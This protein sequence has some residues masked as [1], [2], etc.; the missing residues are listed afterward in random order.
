MRMI[1]M[2][3][4]KTPTLSKGVM[5]KMGM[6]LDL[7]QKVPLMMYN[8]TQSGW[9]TIYNWKLVWEFMHTTT[10]W[11]LLWRRGILVKVETLMNL[12]SWKTFFLWFFK[13]PLSPSYG[14]YGTGWGLWGFASELDFSKG[15]KI[16]CKV[17][18][19]TIIQLMQLGRLCLEIWFTFS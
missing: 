2:I 11:L 12:H 7:V 4:E 15:D 19:L 17:F 18:L 16:I 13:A 5:T 9:S 1:L 6:G 3:Q 10:R 14:S 8:H